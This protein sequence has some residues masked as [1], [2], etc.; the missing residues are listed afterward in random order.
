MSLCR[1]AVLFRRSRC[2][3][4]GDDRFL[5]LRHLYRSSRHFRMGAS[6]R[7][8]LPVAGT[9]SQ[10]F[11]PPRSAAVMRPT[12]SSAEMATSVR[13]VFSSP[14]F[15]NR[16]AGLRVPAPRLQLPINGDD[17]AALRGDASPSAPGVRGPVPRAQRLHQRGL[18]CS[19]VAEARRMQLDDAAR[20]LCAPGRIVDRKADGCV[21]D[22]ARRVRHLFR[23]H[24]EPDGVDAGIALPQT[25][26]AVLALRDGVDALHDSPFQ[27]EDRAGGCRHRRVPAGRGGGRSPPLGGRGG[28]TDRIPAAGC[29]ARDTPGPPSR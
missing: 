8:F 16:A 9:S 20:Q 12:C 26:A 28:R 29:A 13:P 18:L 23:V 27:H 11:A 25:Q 14:S 4:R 1:I 2:C 15:A 5:S 22:V 10:N 3:G 17:M 24:P 19:C 7:F 21:H 6:A